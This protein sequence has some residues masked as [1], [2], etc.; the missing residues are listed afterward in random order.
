M[1]GDITIGVSTGEIVR[2]I[3]WFIF[4]SGFVV[5][6]VPAIKVNPISFILK[7]FGKKI[8]ADLFDKFEII[9]KKLDDVEFENDMRRIKDLKS[10]ILAFARSLKYFDS[11]D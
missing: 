4:V 8:N 10:E 9:D 7:L 5:E 1:F 6:I 3:A 2:Y 11:Q